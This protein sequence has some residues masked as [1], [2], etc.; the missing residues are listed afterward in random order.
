MPIEL[1]VSVL[2]LLVNAAIGAVVW[3][4]IDD[5]NKSLYEWYSEA[6]GGPI[7]HSLLSALVLEAWPI[8]LW[9]WWRN[10]N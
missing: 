7:A 9:L 10:R 6:P 3:S 1:L 8:G 2:L 5:E 4:S